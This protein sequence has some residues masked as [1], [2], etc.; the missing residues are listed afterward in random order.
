MG[1]SVSVLV[2]FSCKS[3]EVVLAGCDRALLW[4][5]ILMS[6]HMCLQVLEYASTFWDG[7][8]TLVSTLVVKVIAASTFPAGLGMM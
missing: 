6:E 7:A 8:K 2:V 4:S 5:L 3:L 1:E